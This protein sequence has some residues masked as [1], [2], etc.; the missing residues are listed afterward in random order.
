MQSLCA[1]RQVSVVPKDIMIPVT[2]YQRSRSSGNL[3]TANQATRQG[4]RNLSAVNLVG[5]SSSSN[6]RLARGGYKKPN[7]VFDYGALRMQIVSYI[8]SRFHDL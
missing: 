8:I 1:I 7:G 2:Q 3:S 5:Q 6:G 4:D